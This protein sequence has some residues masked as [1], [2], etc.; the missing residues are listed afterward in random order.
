[1]NGMTMLSTIAMLHQCEK[2]DS[3]FNSALACHEV[4]LDNHY[5]LH[6]IKPAKIQTNIYFDLVVIF[7]VNMFLTLNI[8]ATV[9]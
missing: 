8:H 4:L 6:T 9:M 3:Y 2:I 5:I 1:M 7:L